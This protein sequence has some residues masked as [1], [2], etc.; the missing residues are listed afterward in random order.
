MNFLDIGIFLGLALAM[1]SLALFLVLPAFLH[2]RPPAASARPENIAAARARL[3]VLRQQQAAGELSV[4]EMAEYESEIKQILVTEVEAEENDSVLPAESA[5][6][7][8]ADKKAAAVVLAILVPGALALYFWLGSPHILFYSVP[9][10]DTVASPSLE[11]ATAGLRRYIVA[12]PQDGDALALM[13]RALT[14]ISN[15]AEAATFFARARKVQ[16]DTLPLLVANIHSLLLAGQNENTNEIDE[17]L[18][19][20][21]LLSPQSQDV[22]LLVDMR[23]K[24]RA[25]GADNQ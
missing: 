10:S 6:D 13:G 17:L 4:E 9:P 23:N 11:D 5:T 19:K 1:L 14:S 20:A 24:Q 15:H 16:G 7:L 8:V 3:R 21:L 2:P 22:L 25:G 12:N 18:E